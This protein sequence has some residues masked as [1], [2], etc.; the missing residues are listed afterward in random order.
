MRC[1]I[2]VVLV[3][4]MVAGPAMPA[5]HPLL[6]EHNAATLDPSGATLSTS[7][8]TL[9]KA[10]LQAVQAASASESAAA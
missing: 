1:A 8:E 4:G 10:I 9:R 2:L 7:D 5:A 3:V 6:G